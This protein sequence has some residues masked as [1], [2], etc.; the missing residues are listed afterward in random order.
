MKHEDVLRKL[1][2]VIETAGSLRETAR[3]WGIS[4]A[5]LSDVMTGNRKPGPKILKH[6]GLECTVKVVR[7]YDYQKK[8]PQ[9]KAGKE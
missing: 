6:M 1:K 8:K 5:Y 7:T 2:A 4:A 9:S 3:C